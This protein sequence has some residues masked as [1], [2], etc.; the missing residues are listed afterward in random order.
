MSR[1]R[2]LRRALVGLLLLSMPGTGAS[3]QYFGRGSTVQGD[4]LHGV[5]A[6]LYGAGYY[7]LRTAQADRIETGTAIML[8]EYM[9][10]ATKQENRE[11]AE[12]RARVRARQEEARKKIRERIRNTPEESDLFKSDALNSLREELLAP[13][14]EASIRLYRLP[15]NGDTIRRV[16][17]FFAQE[18]KTFSMQRLSAKGKW[19]VALRGP[20]LSR[21]RRNY[22][23][24]V[25]NAL[26]Q[27]NA[28]KGKLM[29]EDVRAVVKAVEELKQ[30][31]D[32]VHPPSRDKIYLDA[33]NY[34]KQ[35]ESSAEMLKSHK[36]EQIICEIDKYSGT[37]LSDLLVFM[38]RNHLM[39]GV[40]AEI[41]DERSLYREL[42]AVLL[43][44]KNGKVANGEQEPLK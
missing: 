4:Y 12:Y 18:D 14:N 8:N 27:L 39:F 11:N 26:D 36:I 25:D 29:V 6:A 42:Y 31:L 2:S 17:F 3:A 38:Q 16:P 33:K 30:K 13:G 22:E 5:G 40:A 19:P 21:E 32:Q 24:V 20:E 15:L 9:A 28:G 1:G 43:E 10:A 44:Q 34:L 7:N 35:L 37:S 23:Q 41:G